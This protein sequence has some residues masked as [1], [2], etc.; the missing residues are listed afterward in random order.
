MRQLVAKLGRLG[1]TAVV[2][3]HDDAGAT[4]NDAVKLTLTRA[5]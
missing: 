2:S 4:R 1:A 3:V 5:R